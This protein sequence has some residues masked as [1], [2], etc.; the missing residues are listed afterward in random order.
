MVLVLFMVPAF[1]SGQEDVKIRKKDFRTGVEIGFKEAWKSVRE[2][3]SL[4]SEGMGTYAQA[5]DHFLFAHQYN[6]SELHR[7][8]GETQA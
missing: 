5:R 2:G 4:Y 1:L 8:C 6:C 7:V 3:N